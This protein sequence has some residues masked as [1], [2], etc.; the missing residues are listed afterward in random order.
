MNRFIK[1]W[2]AILLCVVLTVAVFLPLLSLRV[3][4]VNDGYLDSSKPYPMFQ[5]NLITYTCQYDENTAK[6]LIQGTVH[7]DIM[8]QYKG[9]FLDVYVIAP[10]QTVEEAVFSSEAENKTSMKLSIKFDFALSA[11]TI[12]ERFS[13]YAVVV[14]TE[15]GEKILV[16]S[17][18][19]IHVSSQDVHDPSNRLPYKGIS[20]DATSLSGSLGAG[21]AIIPVYLNRLISKQS[22]GMIYPM[23]TGFCY[24][25][26]A[27]VE[28]L[29]AK[30]RTYSSSGTRVYLQLLL[31]ANGSELALA[32][33]QANGAQYDFPNL[34]NPKNLQQLSI[35]STFLAERYQTNQSGLL[36]GLIVGSSIDRSS[37]N[38]TGGLSLE[39]YAEQYA[40]YLTVIASSARIQN[41][42]IDIILPF[43][44]MDTYSNVN[45]PVEAGDYSPSELLEQILSILDQRLSKKFLCGTMIESDVVPM[46]LSQANG[47]PAYST[48]QGILSAENLELYETYLNQLQQNYSCAPSHFLYRWNISADLNENALNCAYAYSYYRLLHC[49]RLFSFVA[50]V[51]SL[52]K[53]EQQNAVSDLAM[54]FRYID[55]MKERDV[56]EP[57]LSYFNASNWNELLSTH[58]ILSTAVRNVYRIR[59]NT[60]VS[61]SFQGSFEYFDFA[62]GNI[63]N[64]FAGAD[65]QKVRADFLS[66]GVRGVRGT[67]LNSGTVTASEMLCLYEFPEN[68]V[69]TPYLKLTLEIADNA[70]GESALYELVISMGN[71]TSM[72]LYEQ[73]VRSGERCEVWLDLTGIPEEELMTNYIKIGAAMIDGT[74]DQFSIGIVGLTGYSEEYD[75][76]ELAELI[77]AERMRIRNQNAENE[78]DKKQLELL[79]LIFGGLFLVSIVIAGIVFY[80]KRNDED[81][82]DEEEDNDSFSNG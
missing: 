12:A 23:E 66:D 24:F 79:W 64:W 51:S 47:S 10:G 52:S 31:E 42:E 30:I 20:S 35:A 5:K 55:T 8:I 21:T 33:G 4:A 36:S 11:L 49:T 77:E 50:S 13:R 59:A 58:L 76:E 57:F 2:I 7:H 67:M 9:A 43:S 3:V 29:D 40:F 38:Y 71:D 75:S 62:L 34:Q 37:Q 63:S 82:T 44:S 22:G 28:T 45:Y 41:S 81:E 54:V 25:N 56:T 27:Y 1:Q 17:P 6:I 68:F 72:I 73:T 61:E 74:A 46:N 16:S 80:I 65:C 19:Y 53:E 60:A 15:A 78:E 14:R 26:R 18:Q 70:V 39:Q 69:Y 48:P 32:N